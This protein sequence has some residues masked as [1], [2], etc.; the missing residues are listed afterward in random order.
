MPS[1]KQKKPSPTLAKPP[2]TKKKFGGRG[3]ASGVGYEVDIA[4]LIAV[5]MLSGGHN[6][7]FDAVS[8][9]EIS[10]LT[11]QS[12]DS[13]DDIVLELKGS[14]SAKI[15]ISAKRRTGRV[16]LQAGSSTFVEVIESFVEQDRALS[17]QA[18]NRS[19][20]VW[21]LPSTAGLA[22]THDLLEALAAFRL[23]MPSQDFRSFLR[24]RSK[25]QAA[26]LESCVSVIKAK[27]KSL[28]GTAAMS[29]VVTGILSRIYV[30]IF[31][32][33]MGSRMERTAM[34]NL[35]ANVLATSKD[36]R[37]AWNRLRDVLGDANRRGLR[38]QARQLR[39]ALTSD[40]ISLRCEDEFAADLETLKSMTR[41]NMVRLREHRFLRFGD[42]KSDEIHLPRQED[43][44]ALEQATKFGHH[45]ITG[46]PGCGKSGLIHL[47]VERLEQRGTPVVLLLAEEVGSGDTSS[48]QVIPT[49]K[50]ALDDV[51]AHWPDGSSGFLITDALDAVRDPDV[52][53]K[54]R[55]M[56]EDIIRGESS[57][58][59]I[60]SVREFDLKHSVTLRELF[61]GSG[62]ATH[63]SKDFEGVAHFHIG[64]LSE[65][66]LDHLIA[67]RPEISPFVLSARESKRSEQLHRS[68]FFLRLAAELLRTG[69]AATRLADWN[70]PTLLLRRF[71]DSRVGDDL[72]EGARESVLQLICQTM[73]KQRIMSLSTKELTLSTDH[74]E[75][76]SE[77]RSRGIL[78][79]PLL[80]NRARVGDEDI[81]FSHHLIHDYA[82]ARSLIPSL[83]SR[84]VA[85]AISE[86]LAPVFYR[87]S[88]VMALDELW[89]GPEGVPGFWKACLE[90]ESSPQLHS[91]T[92]ILAPLL[93][94][95]RVE[96][97]QDLLP[98]IE[99]ISLS[100][101]EDHPSLKA[102][103][104]LSAGLEDAS[105]ETIR[106]GA[107]AW[108]EYASR[109]GV[110]LA[111]FPVLESALVYLVARL[112][113]VNAITINDDS[114]WINEAGR[115]LLKHHLNKPVNQGWRYVAAT[116]TRAICRTYESELEASEA[117]LLALMD[118]ER[119][120]Q[121][122]HHDLF[123][124][125]HEIKHIG[126]QGRRVVTELFA[127]VFSDEPEPD[128][129]R[130]NGSLIL[131]MRTQT[132]DDWNIIRYALGEYYSNC[133]NMSADLAT[134][135]VCTV[136]SQTE[137]TRERKTSQ[138]GMKKLRA[139]F[140]LQGIDVELLN[141]GCHGW[142]RE[143]ENEEN[144]IL[145]AFEARLREWATKRH[146]ESLILAVKTFART[147]HSSV[148]W[149]V[150]LEIASQH[151]E[152][153]GL[154][155]EEAVYQPLI[156]TLPDYRYGGAALFSALHQLGDTE[157]RRK[158]ENTLLKLPSSTPLLA[159]D[160]RHPT[161]GWIIYSQ[162]VLLGEL[163]D[164]NIVLEET[165]LLRQS[166]GAAGELHTNQ[167]PD[168]L[169][170]FTPSLGGSSMH[171]ER[172]QRDPIILECSRLDKDLQQIEVQIDNGKTTA[173]F[174]STSLNTIRQAVKMVRQHRC[175]HSKLTDDLW[176]RVVNVSSH[177]V[178]R[179]PPPNALIW[180][181]DLRRLL[182]KAASDSVPAPTKKDLGT[183]DHLSTW[184]SP[185]PR[186]DAARAL[187]FLVLRMKA[188]DR[189]IAIAIR[190]LSSDPSRVVRHH[191]AGSLHALHRDAP[192]LMWKLMDHLI[193]NE[194]KFAVLDEL[195]DS[196]RHLLARDSNKAL[197]R[198]ERIGARAENSARPDHRIHRHIASSFLFHHLGNGEARSWAYIEN[199]IA[200]CEDP[201]TSEALIG[202]LHRCRSGKW[203]TAG[204]AIVSDE[205][206]DERRKRAWRFFRVLLTSAQCKLNENREQWRLSAMNDNWEKVEK[207][208]LE[209]RMSGLYKIVDGI[210]AQLYFGSGT[211]AE[212]QK[213]NEDR[214]SDVQ[215][216]RFWHDSAD[217]F[218]AL[219]N[220]PHPHTA[221]HV[222]EAMC[223]LMP[224]DPKR[225][226]LCGAKSIQTSA[227]WGML[228]E[229]LVV[230]DIVRLIQRA[231]SDHREMFRTTHEGNSE[232]LEELLKL[233]D[234]FV[235]AG[236]AKARQLTHK[237]EDIY[238]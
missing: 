66:E 228:Q 217:L 121:F 61:P 154:L 151:P 69:V 201:G 161:P 39:Q 170:P 142:G 13:V 136:W 149:Q 176:G 47:L 9:T 89:D 107:S 112:L 130:S 27:W 214:L 237:L 65:A 123:D 193:E 184:S 118:P 80:K 152:S 160:A 19:R 122:P 191:L 5:K 35:S 62:T 59:V 49:L 204:D 233:L 83:A 238:R 216:R 128:D 11:L 46:E 131:S 42:T 198:M 44:N 224:A 196:I 45:L 230:D 100:P 110:L 113:D 41:R 40:E 186:S 57:W 165:R 220:E 38:L 14:G 91:F 234:L 24:C 92:R 125:A 12:A 226:F 150:V 190:R 205:T 70:S 156:L 8:G 81:R 25:K 101:S 179:S 58:T 162:D 2:N 148:M 94:A 197:P 158:L 127:A 172:D 177:M 4:A 223:H 102:A 20:F 192:D 222:V 115:T 146:W 134:E 36:A 138:L 34:S 37:K 98:L 76:I 22:V 137:K 200:H 229:H 153:L 208:V 219:A 67:A 178:G 182:L 194:L 53:M 109:L 133:Y 173:L 120:K 108:C 140:H 163:S 29:D 17:A 209:S 15:Y 87:Q 168:S 18:R 169:T 147:N 181:N 105:P 135:L 63:A 213:K 23:E 26:A 31:D 206:T 117:A 203:L 236:W 6:E 143:F 99:T 180:W 33:E 210:A 225:A 126:E 159:E 90:L 30:E 114:R 221:K 174:A 21:A 187:P 211:F 77:L 183:E 78:Q 235:D 73:M 75:A 188:I 164:A 199:L 111:R 43:I 202:Q 167:R 16:S 84:F 212:K 207:S 54:L 103:R 60:A 171:E 82:I 129:W 215:A 119:L 189:P 116:G 1:R 51:L 124:L 72:G 195:V 85:F 93:A 232:C 185:S 139:K 145:R 166:R 218:E 74:R 96:C 104:H 144:T 56:L 79:S 141:D 88:F 50:H 48:R 71:W 97:A 132:R 64:R 68:P 227:A 95:R 52:L 3:T 55:R 86:P 175:T 28:T 32:F 157:R 7:V 155:M 106:L 231:L 10:S